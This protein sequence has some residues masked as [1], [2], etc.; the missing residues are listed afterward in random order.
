M[1]FCIPR[2]NWWSSQL[3]C[4]SDGQVLIE[5]LGQ[6]VYLGQGNDEGAHHSE[7]E[8]EAK[9]QRTDHQL[10]AGEAKQEPGSHGHYKLT[11]CYQLPIHSL[12]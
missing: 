11:D 9:V 4:I 2:V 12:Y 7:E 3:N 8:T 5:F 6:E 1:F 10:N